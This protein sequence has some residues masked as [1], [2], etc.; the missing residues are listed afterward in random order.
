MRKLTRKEMLE[1]MY[2]HESID[3][4][5]ESDFEKSDEIADEMFARNW[6]TKEMD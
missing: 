6:I 1:I 2:A 5:E 3:E 4:Q